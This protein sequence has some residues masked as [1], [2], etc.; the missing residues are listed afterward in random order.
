MPKKHNKSIS[1]RPKTSPHSSLRSSSHLASPNG[2]L[3][4]SAASSDS[5]SVNNLISHLRQTQLSHEANDSLSTN[6]L[7]A[8]PQ[9]TVHPSLRNLL[10]VP[11]TPPPRPRVAPRSVLG[12]RSRRIPGPPPPESWL[13]GSIHAPA[14]V[15]LKEQNI[16]AAS[17]TR[18]WKYDSHTLPGGNL[19]PK[20]SLAD[21]VSRTM[22]KRWSFHMQFDGLWL[23]SLP[24]RL[25]EYLLRYI[26]KEAMGPSTSHNISGTLAILWPQ[27][28]E[29]QNMLAD[30]HIEVQG[31]AAEVTQLD[32]SGAIGTWLTVKTLGRQ[33]QESSSSTAPRRLVQA[34]PPDTTIEDS[35]DI[36]D[37]WDNTSQDNEVMTPLPE[38]LRHTAALRFSNLA[39]LSLALS[40]ATAPEHSHIPSWSSLLSLSA[41]LLT[42]SSLSL[43][44]WPIPTLTP[45]ATASNAKIENPI[46]RSLPRVQY[47]STD[48]YAEF[49]NEWSE[50][51]SILRK[52]S[53]NL[54][55]L[56]WLDLS[57]CGT[58]WGALCWEGGSRPDV[59][60]VDHAE[61]ERL[62]VKDGP[63]WNGG[64]RGIE[65]VGLDIGWEPKIWNVVDSAETKTGSEELASTA[66]IN[67]RYVPPS[68]RTARMRGGPSANS[69]ADNGGEPVHL[70]SGADSRLIRQDWDVEV[71][72]E[73]HYQRKELKRY[74]ELVNR[75][76]K[77]AK[78][79]QALRR[80][81]RGKWIEFGMSSREFVA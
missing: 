25:K 74:L 21:M 39:H 29:A 23:A 70:G 28:E 19:P 47:S 9:R 68:L 61:G 55:C 12:P 73:K 50:S 79:I 20:G 62:R 81:N 6:L 11:D 33:L 43:A 18:L 49:E 54:Y 40:P 56:R 24:V 15:R 60:D 52:L 27:S 7:S 16:A 34:T 67:D 8:Q 36:P 71:E 3:A 44:Y 80:Q 76:E 63:E 42:L 66:T 48:H 26:A 64:W 41:H 13:T 14:S 2:R 72:R 45:H 78:G 51:A 69:S 58:W 46:S 4:A 30:M 10:D 22:A 65:F 77:V 17:A 38:S 32:L 35:N 5:P 31:D 1:V 59:Y 75:A 53:R 37:A 57:G